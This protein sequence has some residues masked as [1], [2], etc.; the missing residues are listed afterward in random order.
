M[1]VLSSVARSLAL[2]SILFCLCGAAL[3]DEQPVASSLTDLEAALQQSDA[4]Q[5]DLL[6]A[7]LS[8]QREQ[9]ELSE[10]L[11]LQAKTVSEK[12]LAL[13]NAEARLAALQSSKA[14]ASLALAQQQDVLSEVL[15][16][17]QRLEQNPPPALV[18]N[19]HDTLEALRGAMMFGAV[20][21]ELR[22]AAQTLQENLAEIEV[23]NAN[24][25][26]EAANNSA[27]LADLKIARLEAQRLLRNKKA[28]AEA[29][30]KNLASE[31][32][33]AIELALQ[34]KNL[35]QL[36]AS[37]AA[38]RQKQELART[39]AEAEAE[40]ARA[41]AEAAERAR[42]AAPTVAFALAQGQLQYP[43]QGQLLNA[44]GTESVL[45]TRI[46]GIVIATNPGAQVIAPASGTIEFAGKFRS[47]GQMLIINP[48][49]GYLVLLSGL[50]QILAGAGQSV[51]AGEPVGMMG[52][53]PA[54]L[55]IANGLP[56]QNSPVLYVEFRQNGDPVDPAPWWI[57]NRKEA[58]R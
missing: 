40:K 23:I 12:E 8:V 31:K 45:G 34:A 35:K 24:L 13:A 2:S 41:L 9:T 54:E 56:K 37:L 51:R 52:Q 21:P 36:L 29:M 25:I 50:E 6:T 17:L 22:A 18:V 43:V 16:G 20:V 32:I 58:M 30:H 19:P 11:I 5:K 42:Q 39:A 33:R 15:A 49:D 57:G 27:A 4:R 14:K 1:I 53:K 3:A 38:E 7:A 46:D 48:G 10:R 47:Y 26:A 28:A 44:F 55:A